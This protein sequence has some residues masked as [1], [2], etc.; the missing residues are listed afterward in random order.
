[1]FKEF[2]EF[3]SKGNI[4][5]LAVAVVIGGA[6][7]KIIASLVNDILNPLIGLA[8]GDTDLANLK[9]ILKE[10][11]G[12]IPE[13]AILYGSFIQT[14]I[15][16]LIIAFVIFIFVKISKNLKKKEEVAE[17]VKEPTLTL[18]QE[19]LKDIKNLLEKK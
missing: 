17:E 10:A 18:D 12:E 1:M 16:F 13:S 6:F 8:I 5:D 3:I 19:L 11:Q 9:I 4:V 14:I 7:G 2:K 15:N